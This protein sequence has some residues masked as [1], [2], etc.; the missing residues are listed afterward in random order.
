MSKDPCV[1]IHADLTFCKNKSGYDYSVFCK[2]HIADVIG[3][4]RASNIQDKCLSKI[5]KIN[6]RMKQAGFL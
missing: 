3:N 6:K 5:R 2:D 1:H 4:S